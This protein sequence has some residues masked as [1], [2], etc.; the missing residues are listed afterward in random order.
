MVVNEEIPQEELQTS[1]SRQCKN[2]A[3]P[4]NDESSDEEEIDSTTCKICKIPWIELTENV[5]ISF[6]AIYTM[7]ISAQSSMTR[8]IFPQLMIFLQ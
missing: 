3:E 5:E 1:P 6:N 8:E 4:W 2:L 7:N